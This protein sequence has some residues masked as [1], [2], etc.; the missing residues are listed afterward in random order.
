MLVQAVV[1][2][3]VVSHLD[4]VWLH[5]VTLSIVVV[6]DVTVIKVANTLFATSVHDNGGDFG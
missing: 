3:Q 6:T 5:G 1:E 4:T 2:Q